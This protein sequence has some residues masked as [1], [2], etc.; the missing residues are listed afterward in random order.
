MKAH[1][2]D[3]LRVHGR[4]VG[5]A[6]HTAQIVEIRE[7]TTGDLFMVRYDDGS[8]ALV[9]PGPDTSIEHRPECPAT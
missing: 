8:E 7:R 1:V 2:G 9:F 5:Q 6:E 3:R 4:I